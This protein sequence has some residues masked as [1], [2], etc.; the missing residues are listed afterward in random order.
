MILSKI[1]NI[2][3]E[4]LDIPPEEISSDTFLVRDLE[5]ESIDYLEIAVE[6]N[7]NFKIDVDDNIIFLKNLRTI[8]EGEGIE[9]LN[10][11]YLYLREGRLLEIINDYKNGPAIKVSD[12]IDY[13]EYYG[14]VRSN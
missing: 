9:A 13:I 4:I 5:M 3:G 10:K 8:Y 2:L 6:V 1:T 11:E 7:Q 12:I 14:S